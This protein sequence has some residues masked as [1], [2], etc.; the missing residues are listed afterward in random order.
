M[1]RVTPETLPGV[2]YLLAD[3]NSSLTLRPMPASR[4][5]IR[6]LRPGIFLAI[7]DKLFRQDPTAFGS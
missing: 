4:P 7:E 5:S 2:P 6:T 3:K 1:L